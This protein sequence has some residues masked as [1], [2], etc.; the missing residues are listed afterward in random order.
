MERSLDG[1]AR[2]H[3]D[4]QERLCCTTL[5]LIPCPMRALGGAHLSMAKP[6]FA[7]AQLPLPIGCRRNQLKRSLKMLK[8]ILPESMH[9]RG[10]RH[11]QSPRVDLRCLGL[12]HALAR[13]WVGDLAFEL[14]V[15]MT[16]RASDSQGIKSSLEHSNRVGLREGA[17]KAH[18]SRS[19][20]RA[21]AW[22]VKSS[23]K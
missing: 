23:I 16:A 20:A 21:R 6:R 14:D 5:E 22:K 4:V 13:C 17:P 12:E 3:F 7:G 10:E 1:L 2:F 8:R 19:M 11:T 18:C 15:G 9:H